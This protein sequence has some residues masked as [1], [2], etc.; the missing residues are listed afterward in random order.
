MD[1]VDFNSG[2]FFA[3]TWA[4][5]QIFV[6]E[7]NNWV[8]LNGYEENALTWKFLA[9]VMVTETLDSEDLMSEYTW[10]PER[11]ELLVARDIENENTIFARLNSRNRV[12]QVSDNECILY[13]LK[14]VSSEPDDYRIKLIIRRL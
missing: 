3:G 12:E 4:V 2:T 7:D 13:G 6:K 8:P 11:K 14:N 9:N 1:S 5:E 10:Y